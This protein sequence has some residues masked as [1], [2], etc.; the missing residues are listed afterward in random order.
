[1]VLSPGRLAVEQTTIKASSKHLQRVA[2]LPSA[3]AYALHCVWKLCVEVCME[4]FVEVRVEVCM[5]VC[6]DVVVEVC[7]EMCV[8]VCVNVCCR[9]A[10][11]LVNHQYGVKHCQPFPPP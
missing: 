10:T 1:M 6:V 3:M 8:N 9:R 4:V 2:D 11:F 5:E 7:V